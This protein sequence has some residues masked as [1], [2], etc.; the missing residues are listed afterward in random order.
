MPSNSRIIRN[1][2]SPRL[3]ASLDLIPIN[4][5]FLPSLYV[6]SIHVPSR[7][8]F[9]H[10]VLGSFCPLG[11]PLPNSLLPVWARVQ[12]VFLQ[13][14]NV[15]EKRV[16]IQLQGIESAFIEEGNQALVFKASP[17]RNP[18]RS[19]VASKEHTQRFVLLSGRFSIA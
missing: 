15:P 9:P 12:V 14:K 5:G 3:T 18:H 17:W 13:D 2:L 7:R 11:L 10:R 4:R 8:P 16:H 6:G 19:P 1:D